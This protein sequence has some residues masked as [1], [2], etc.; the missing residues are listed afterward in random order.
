MTRRPK[1]SRKPANLHVENLENR[2]LLAADLGFAPEIVSPDVVPVQVEISPVG[3][4][5]VVRTHGPA[6]PHHD[7]PL[8]ELRTRPFKVLGG[9]EDQHTADRDGRPFVVVGGGD[10][11]VQM[12]AKRPTTG[13]AEIKIGKDPIKVATLGTYDRERLQPMTVQDPE[14]SADE[15]LP[16]GVKEDRSG[17]GIRVTEVRTRVKSLPPK[18]LGADRECFGGR[19][20]REDSLGVKTPQRTTGV[21]ATMTTESGGVSQLDRVWAGYGVYRPSNSVSSL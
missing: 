9:F 2:E 12:S 20:H 14:S 8:N 5:H 3:I 13:V 6:G 17:S 4:A 19:T 10:E 1:K 18:P 21:T 11:D 16:C 7:S 15:P